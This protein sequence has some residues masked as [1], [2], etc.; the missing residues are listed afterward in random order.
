MAVTQGVQARAL[1]KT[2]LRNSSE[3][4][5]ETEFGLSGVPSGLAK[6]KSMSAR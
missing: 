5:D 6:I 1:G 2:S 3:I 4:T